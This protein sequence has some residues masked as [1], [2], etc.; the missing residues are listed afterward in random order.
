[1][2]VPAHRRGSAS[3]VVT[4]L[5]EADGYCCVPEDVAGVAAGDLLPVRWL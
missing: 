4:S 3:H 1:M 5:A 2:A